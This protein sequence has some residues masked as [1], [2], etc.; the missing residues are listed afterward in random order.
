MKNLNKNITC[1]ILLLVLLTGCYKRRN[2]YE[3]ADD[4]GLSRFTSRGYNILTLYINDSAYINPYSYYLLGG[5]SNSSVNIQKIQTNAAQ[6]T[7]G[8]SWQIEYHTSRG[9]QLS[10]YYNLSLFIPVAKNFNEKD[11]ET[12]QGKRFPYDPAVNVIIQLNGGYNSIGN[13]LLSGPASIYFVKIGPQHNPGATGSYY[14]S[15]LFE[16]NTGSNNIRITKGR[17][18]FYIDP[19]QLNF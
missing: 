18:D 16:G 1:L 3:D 10:S 6:D 9:D 8:I 2:F 4:P 7:L 12:W 5:G 13:V 19:L 15:G 17:F 14:F 11:F